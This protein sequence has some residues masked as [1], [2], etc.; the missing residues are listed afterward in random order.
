M[1]ESVELAG[2][3]EL[4]RNSLMRTGLTLRT[5]SAVV[6]ECFAPA[7]LVQEALA[8]RSPLYA[9]GPEV[10]LKVALTLA[11]GATGS[12]NAFAVSAVPE[13]TAVHCLPGT[14]MLSL[15]FVAGV[16]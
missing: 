16:A 5:F 4:M 2:G 14:V 10:T 13:T 8:T 11:P 1:N 12:E 7:G 9:A 3:P 15:T 6:S